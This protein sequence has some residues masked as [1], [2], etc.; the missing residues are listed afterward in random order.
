MAPIFMILSRP[1]FTLSFPSLNHNCFESYFLSEGGKAIRQ[2]MTIS[3]LTQPLL[4]EV[5]K[6]TPGWS[7]LQNSQFSR[8]GNDMEPL[9]LVNREWRDVTSELASDL[10]IP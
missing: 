10:G 5:I 8:L 4:T 6:R 1:C 9:S 3:H 7:E 2:N